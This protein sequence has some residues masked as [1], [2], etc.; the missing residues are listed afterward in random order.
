MRQQSGINMAVSGAHRQTFRTAQRM[1]SMPRDGLG[2]NR[3]SGC[4][5]RKG[6]LFLFPQNETDIRETEGGVHD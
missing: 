2:V 3:G 6:D 4:A 1:L 5:P